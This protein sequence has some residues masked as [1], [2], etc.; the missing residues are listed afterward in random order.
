MRLL[1]SKI[2]RNG[3]QV[4]EAWESQNRAS[5][6]VHEE[7][8]VWYEKFE[9]TKGIIK[10]RKSKKDRQY[11][12]EKKNDKMTNKKTIY[13]SLRWNLKIEHEPL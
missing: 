5:A 9:D 4:Q 2:T 11:N 1:V 8:S 13:I 6:M 7:V 3:F 10:S 12:G